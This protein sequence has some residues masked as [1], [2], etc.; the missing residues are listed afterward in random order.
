MRK[1]ILKCCQAHLKMLGVHRM[2]GGIV[3]LDGQE[4]ACTHVERNLIK[5]KA[6]GSHLRNHLIGEVQTR[7]RGSNRALEL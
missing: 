6:I 3:A 2:L 1:Q 5:D 4:R 7:R